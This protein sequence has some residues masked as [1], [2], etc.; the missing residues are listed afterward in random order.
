MADS[1][2]DVPRTMKSLVAPRY[3]TPAGYEVVEVPVPE[4]KKPHEVLV[5]MR[6]ACVNPGDTQVASG[7][8]RFFQS[9]SF[10]IKL[11]VEGAGVVV[12]VGSAVETVK[13][14]DEVYMLESDPA[15][16]F[17]HIGF[18]SE[19]ALASEKFVIRKPANMTFVE[20]ASLLGSTMPG[21]EAF[22][23]VLR[24][25]PEGET[26]EGKTVLVT[27]GLGALGSVGTQLAKNVY[28]AGKVLTT[29]STPK[30]PLVETYT[31]GIVDKVIDYKTQDILKVVPRGS[32]DV[33]YNA[34]WGFTHLFPL[35]NPKSGVFI[36]ASG[37][38]NSRS[39][40]PVFPHLPRVIGWLADL[41]QWWYL[42]RF[43]GT[44]VHYE[45]IMSKPWDRQKLERAGEVINAGLVKAVTTEARFDDI[46]AVRRGC[47][48]TYDGHGG[49]GKF[50]VT[51][52]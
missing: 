33:V 22:E 18:I 40:K 8:V 51:F 26:I 44:S 45:M 6:A 35:V 9:F 15:S 29:V 4:L 36:T 48:H 38:P 32:V 13:P 31:P 52:A 24:H 41:L 17:E 49:L 11:G 28:G 1:N 3:C 16:N 5:R 46:E 12:Q 7:A 20:A 50:V 39:L 47:Q 21:I 19:Y 25:M 30:V 42:W 14:G 37:I 23:T 2:A 43:V 10:P 34:P 27:A